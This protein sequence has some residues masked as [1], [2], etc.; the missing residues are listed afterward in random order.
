MVSKWCRIWSIHSIKSPGPCRCNKE[1]ILAATFRVDWFPITCSHKGLGSTCRAGLMGI[2]HPAFNC[3]SVGFGFVFACAR[4]VCVLLFFFPLNG[5]IHCLPWNSNRCS[6][7][8][9]L[10]SQPTQGQLRFSLA[11]A[12]HGVGRSSDPEAP[13]FRPEG[14]RPAFAALGF[15]CL[16][17][18]QASRL[19][20]HIYIYIYLIWY[21]CIYVHSRPPR[22]LLLP[23]NWLSAS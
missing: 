4:I 17:R 16:A 13:S 20:I 22:P 14:R 3:C 6:F 19:L 7:L 15:L 2:L 21:L 8:S 11:H 12:G 10:A 18:M 5:S 9:N 1:S 23:D